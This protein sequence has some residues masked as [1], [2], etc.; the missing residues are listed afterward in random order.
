MVTMLRDITPNMVVC[1]SWTG[2]D[3]SSVE[4][5]AQIA[6]QHTVHSNGDHE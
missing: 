6:C 5:I 4:A 3:L 2:L 1:E